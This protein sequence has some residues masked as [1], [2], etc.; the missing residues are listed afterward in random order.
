MSSS[1]FVNVQRA[2]SRWE[3]ACD[4]IQSFLIPLLTPS[5]CDFMFTALDVTESCRMGRRWWYGILLI[6]TTINSACEDSQ[7]VLTI[8][9]IISWFIFTLLVYILSRTKRAK[10]CRGSAQRKERFR[11]TDKSVERRPRII[12][13]KF[14]S[15]IVCARA[16]SSNSPNWFFMWQ[17]INCL[18]ALGR[19]IS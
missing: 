13:G 9:V 4:S 19:R 7:G 1:Q 10:E 11:T 14:Q 12:E 6:Q 17:A 15:H 3:K 16:L 5:S 18:M 8:S 2:P